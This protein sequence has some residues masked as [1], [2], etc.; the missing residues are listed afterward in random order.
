[1]RVLC[2]RLPRRGPTSVGLLCVFGRAGL[3]EDCSP[4]AR[5]VPHRAVQGARG[6]LRTATD[7]HAITILRS[8]CGGRQA[9]EVAA[10]CAGTAPPRRMCFCRAQQVVGSNPTVG[11]SA[12]GQ[13]PPEPRKNNPNAGR[14]QR[15]AWCGIAGWPSALRDGARRFY[16][17]RTSK[18]ARSR[19]AKSRSVSSRG[20]GLPSTSSSM[21]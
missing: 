17:A 9:L 13:R 4:D 14:F 8:N 21:L 7:G 15:F 2:L 10:S 11:S 16:S 20:S 12:H 6:E 1:M 19:R 5:D 3:S 18:P